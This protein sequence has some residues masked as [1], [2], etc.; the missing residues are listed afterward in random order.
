LGCGFKPGDRA[1]IIQPDVTQFVVY[2]GVLRAGPCCRP[3]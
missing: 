1:G 3:R 2:C